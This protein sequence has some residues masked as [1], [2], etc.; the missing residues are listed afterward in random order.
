M[1]RALRFIECR[2]LP[3]H[4]RISIKE[5]YSPGETPMLFPPHPHHHI[6][7]ALNRDVPLA[8]IVA[9]H[10][11][12]KDSQLIQ[13]S[14]AAY[15]DRH[16]FRGL[17]NRV[18]YHWS[19]ESNQTLTF[20][21]QHPQQY[22]QDKLQIFEA[23]GFIPYN[24]TYVY[25]LPLIPFEKTTFEYWSLNLVN[26]SSRDIW[27]RF[28]NEYSHLFN[29]PVSMTTDQFC[30]SIHRHTLFYI[31]KLYNIHVGVMKV[32]LN[33]RQLTIQEIH[34]DGDEKVIQEAISFLQQKFYYMFEY[35]DEV[36]FA[37]TSLQPD[38]Q[39]VVRQQGASQKH[40]GFFMMT[41]EVPPTPLY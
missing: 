28:R 11:R 5:L 32:R 15:R 21:L 16:V 10:E 13:L 31:L 35:I 8:A 20:T 40:T 25:T 34:I 18:L 27:L 38:L 33:M 39:Y 12:Y 4:E 26:Y 37:I 36:H 17:L 24:E 1:T 3:S 22:D 23:T 19:R 30:E 7:I 2:Q 14:K 41:K 29:V 6:H 9:N